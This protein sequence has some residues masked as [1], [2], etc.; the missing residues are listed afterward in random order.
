MRR[1]KVLFVGVQLNQLNQP[2][3]QSTQASKHFTASIYRIVVFCRRA[4]WCVVHRCMVV[5]VV[6]I[7]IIRTIILFAGVIILIQSSLLPSG[8]LLRLY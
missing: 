7:I 5:V 3:N 1:S 8:S 6:V 2:I 4:A